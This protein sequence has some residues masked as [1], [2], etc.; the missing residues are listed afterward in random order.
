MLVKQDSKR[1]DNDWTPSGLRVTFTGIFCISGPHTGQFVQG[2][3]NRILPPS[4]E[5]VRRK[6]CP[7]DCSIIR[8][9]P[10]NQ[11]LEKRVKRS[12]K[13]L[14]TELNMCNRKPSFI[15]RLNQENTTR[16]N[17]ESDG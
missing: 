5:T 10:S 4:T 1:K 3:K 11:N 15:R 2:I 13:P 7:L 16:A 9:R 17:F 8:K 12:L 14:L 6:I